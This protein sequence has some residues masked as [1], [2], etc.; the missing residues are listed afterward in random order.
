MAEI[1]VEEP[2]RV[3]ASLRYSS[4]I[5]SNEVGT[6]RLWFE[7]PEEFSGWVTDLADPFLVA[8]L[9]QMMSEGEDVHV[10]GDLS[11]GLIE[12][13]QAFMDL[14]SSWRPDRCRPIAISADRWIK[15]RRPE[16]DEAAM[17]FSGGL[18]AQTSL[19]RHLR[20]EAG[21]RTRSIGA[22]IYTRGFMNGLADSPRYRAALCKTAESVRFFGKEKIPLIAL[23]SNWQELNTRTMPD[24]IGPGLISF[25]HLFKARF[26]HGLLAS[27][28]TYSDLRIYGSHPFSDPLLGHEDFR[29]ESDDPTSSRLDKA[30]YLSDKPEALERLLICHQFDDAARNCGRCEKCYRTALCFMVHGKDVPKSIPIDWDECRRK[31]AYRKTFREDPE[32]S[33]ELF[34][35]I[36]RDRMKAPELVRFQNQYRLQTS[37]QLIKNLLTTWGLRD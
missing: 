35:R 37:K 14:W 19:Q 2:Q 36:R 5:E 12:P 6:R 34:Q 7:V 13:L 8:N 31:K 11:A 18:D 23:V 10:R 1:T 3:G 16:T 29:V 4:V 33:R 22:C 9:F 24:S 15:N 32:A 17:L 20:E 21:D 26:R 28:M 27:S 25:L 30:L